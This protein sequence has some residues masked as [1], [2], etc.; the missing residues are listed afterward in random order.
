MCHYAS[1]KSCADFSLKMHQKRLAAGLRP[2]PLERLQRSPDLLA[3][4]K[5]WSTVKG[6]GSTGKRRGGIAEEWGSRAEGGK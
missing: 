6:G 5:G 3:G 4:F 2:Y 1:E